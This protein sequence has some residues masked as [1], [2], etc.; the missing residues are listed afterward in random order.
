[1]T[2]KNLTIGETIR[3]SIRQPL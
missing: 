1:L 3:N 2:T